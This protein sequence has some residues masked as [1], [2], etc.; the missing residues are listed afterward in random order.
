MKHKHSILWAMAAIPLLIIACNKN[1]AMPSTS[2]TTITIE[3]VLDSKPLV[4]YGSFKNTGASPVVM[5]GEAISIKFSAAKGQALSFATMYGWSNDLFFA[6]ANPGIKLYQDNG[7]PVEGDVS[8]QIKLWDNGTRINQMP[9]AAVIHPGTTETTPRAITEVN[10]TDAQGNT[11]APAS[12]LMKATLHYEGNSNFTLIITNVSGVTTNPTPFSPGVWAISYSV[13]GNLLN[14]NPLFEVGKPS[15]NG[16]TNIAEMGDNS[17]LGN[18]INTQTGIFTPLSPVLVVLYKGI[19]NPIYKIGEN[20]R[21]KGLKDLAQKGDASGLAAYL[22]TL[23]GVKAVYILPAAS[24]TVLLPK[25][26]AQA[27]SSVSQQLS[28][29]SGDRIAIA[30]MYGLSNDWFFAT[31][32]NGIDATVKGDVSYSIGLF[33]NGTAINQFPGAGN[34]QAGLGGTPVTER[35]PIAEV[36][37]PNGFTTL[38]SISSIIKVTIN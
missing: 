12:T 38:P 30:S 32:D 26:G 21:G 11:Y 8:A 4:E 35:K 16:L 1:D 31:K 2:A 3:N 37:N 27:G 14:P 15:V 29:A 13:G 33:D 7:T 24:S 20:D 34:E 19:E 10:G 28:I 18:Y 23:S 9:G 17:V 6:P 36:P 5:P 25:I 22:K